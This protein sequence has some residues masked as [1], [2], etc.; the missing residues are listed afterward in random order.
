LAD[1][2]SQ[3]TE[4]ILAGDEFKQRM[5][6]LFREDEAPYTRSIDKILEMLSEA[7]QQARLE[8]EEAE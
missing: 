2:L 8:F 6:E 4:E 5:L 3:K 1:F 7:L